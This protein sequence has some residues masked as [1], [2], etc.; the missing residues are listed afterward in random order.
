MY[1]RMPHSPCSPDSQT[2]SSST[3][4]PSRVSRGMPGASATSSWF[5]DEKH[6]WFIM[7]IIV[8][9]YICHIIYIYIC[10]IY[11]IYMSYICH[12]YVIYMSYICHIYVIYIYDIYSSWNPA[13]KAGKESPGL[14]FK[15]ATCGNEVELSWTWKYIVVKDSSSVNADMKNAATGLLVFAKINLQ[16]SWDDNS[17]TN[18]L[19]Q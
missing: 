18:S 19:L 2:L 9:I 1:S 15:R 10:H 4:R 6:Q 11:V 3:R 13:E 5:R 8:H 14:D 17:N 16:T 7:F 12:I